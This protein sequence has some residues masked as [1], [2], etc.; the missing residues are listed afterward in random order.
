MKRFIIPFICVCAILVVVLYLTG[1]AAYD[2]TM[3]EANRSL[4]VRAQS[5]ADAVDRVLQSRMIQV[6][7]FAAL[8]TLRA[9]AASDDAERPARMALARAELQSM[10]DADPNVRAVGMV[11]TTGTVILSTD[12][13]MLENWSDRVFVREALRGQIYASVPARD[14]GEV[15]QYY[16]APVLN[17]A[18]DI[19]GGLVVRVAVQEMWDVLGDQFDVLL[20][21]QNGVRISDHSA[22]PQNFVALAPPNVDVL[23]RALAE[24]QYGTEV[25]QIRFTNLTDLMTAVTRNQPQATYRDSKGQVVHAALARLKIFPWTVIVFANEEAML[26]PARDII[27]DQIKIA[28]VSAVVAASAILVTQYLSAPDEN[29]K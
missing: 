3:A 5:A 4:A 29:T 8:P 9:F 6:F 11:D 13:T 18:G 20:V 12:K 16:S 21:D 28:V 17:N 23:N 19:A 10:V 22:A 15:S 14:L 2:R 1:S 27:W 26:A 25:T 7:T 24:K